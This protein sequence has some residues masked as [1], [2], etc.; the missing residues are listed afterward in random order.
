MCPPETEQMAAMAD[1]AYKR[2]AGRA[3]RVTTTETVA[4]ESTQHLTLADLRALIERTAN[5]PADTTV[6]ITEGMHH[7]GEGR[8]PDRITLTRN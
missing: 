2:A 7:R 5:W 1:A 3:A 6:S 8:S 4:I